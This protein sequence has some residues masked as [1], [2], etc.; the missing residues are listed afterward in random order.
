VTRLAF[1]LG[2]IGA[3]AK[4]IQHQYVHLLLDVIQAAPNCIQLSVYAVKARIKVLSHLLQPPLN[5]AEAD[6]GRGECWQQYGRDSDGRTKDGT[7]F[8]F[9]SVAEKYNST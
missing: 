5:P 8:G 6:P 7:R 3:P 9:I 1:E 4:R 2:R